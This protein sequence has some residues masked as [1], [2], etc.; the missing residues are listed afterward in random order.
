[1]KDDYRTAD[2]TVPMR[3]LLDVCVLSTHKPWAVTAGH[4]D[5][6]RETGFSDEAI[7]DAFQVAGYFNYINRI[8]DAL[9]VDLE[10]EMPPM[11]AGWEREPA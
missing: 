8:A 1:M 6:L 2:I 7:H 4:I 10:P 11:P 3:K 9:G 5:E